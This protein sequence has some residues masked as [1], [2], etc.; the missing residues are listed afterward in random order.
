ML[1]FPPLKLD[2]PNPGSYNHLNISLHLKGNHTKNCLPHTS[3]HLLSHTPSH[4]ANAHLPTAQ[5]QSQVCS[6]SSSTSSAYRG[7][8]LTSVPVASALWVSGRVSPFPHLASTPSHSSDYTP[9]TATRDTHRW[10]EWPEVLPAT[11]KRLFKWINLKKTKTK[12]TKPT[13]KHNKAQN[14]NKKPPNNLPLPRCK[15]QSHTG[16]CFQFCLYKCTLC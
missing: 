5:V 7:T 16:L 3:K 15:N 1:S 8:S 12:Q 14:Q 2:F 6:T 10:D 13:N 9:R 11:V 4:T